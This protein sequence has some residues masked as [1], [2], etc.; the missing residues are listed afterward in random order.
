MK[1]FKVY[2]GEKFTFFLYFVCHVPKTH[3]TYA[4]KIIFFIISLCFLL[5]CVGSCQ[6]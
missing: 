5:A 1:K 3:N 2:M 6:Q 4:Y